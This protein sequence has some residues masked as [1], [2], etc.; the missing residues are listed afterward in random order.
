MMVCSLAVGA[1]GARPRGSGENVRRHKGWVEHVPGDGRVGRC[2]T[3][4]D[5]V[6]FQP[7]RS[8]MALGQLEHDAAVGQD[9]PE[10]G[11]LALNAGEHQPA[12]G[13]LG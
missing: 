5:P 4:E 9:F 2:L 1:D 7:T 8:A 10:F 13:P 11:V 3:A 12:K 6:V